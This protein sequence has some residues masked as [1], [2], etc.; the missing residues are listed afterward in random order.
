MIYV[1][2]RTK[3][4]DGS[5]LRHGSAVDFATFSFKKKKFN[6]YEKNQKIREKTY[7]NTKKLT[8]LRLFSKKS[9]LER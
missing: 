4:A 9:A 2:S 1:V 8:F 5:F 3:K 7:K 6:Q